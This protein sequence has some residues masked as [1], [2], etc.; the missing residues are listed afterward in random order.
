LK[1]AY[2]ELGRS[3]GWEKRRTEISSIVVG[4]AGILLVAGG[5]LSLVWFR[6]VP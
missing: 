6:R 1:K 2:Q 5:L 4:G 3:I